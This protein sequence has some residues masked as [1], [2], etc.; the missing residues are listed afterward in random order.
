M[1]RAGFGDAGAGPG[2]VIGDD[3]EAARLQ[4]LETARFMAARSTPRW[5]RS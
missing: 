2:R 4:R 1:E 3:I 5:P